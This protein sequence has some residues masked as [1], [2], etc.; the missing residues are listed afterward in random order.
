MFALVERFFDPIA[1]LIVFGGTLLATMA[2]ASRGDILR[3]VRALH[4]LLAASPDRDGLVAEKAVRHIQRISEYKGIV[5]AD[6]V[7]TPV[8]FVQRAAW[9]LAVGDGS[10]VFSTW[11]RE[12]LDERQARHDGVIAL[13]RQASEVAPAMG[14]IGTVLGLIA[15]F[16]QMN[17]TSAMGPAMATAMLTT[18]YG[19]FIAFVI[20]GPV[21]ARLERLSRCE[22]RWQERVIDRLETLAREEDAAIELWRNRHQVRIA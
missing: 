11:A 8:E 15:M 12:D 3:A 22:R 5:C 4:P 14:M 19:L 13:W 16:A 2:S 20:A 9:R 7:R 21:A 10:D 18:L 6:R 17:D 1:F